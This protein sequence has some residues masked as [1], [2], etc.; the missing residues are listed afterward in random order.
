MFG[1][2]IGYNSTLNFLFGKARGEGWALVKS[3]AKKAITSLSSL[4]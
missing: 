3:V 2:F 1:W 4:W